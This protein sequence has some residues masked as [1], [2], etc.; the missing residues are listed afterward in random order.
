[1]SDHARA[2][3]RVSTI[4]PVYNGAATIARAIDSALAQDFEGQEIIVVNDG[5]TDDTAEA[6]AQY[7]DQI[8][9]VNKPNGGAASA[10]NTGIAIAKG[11]FVAFLD[12]DDIWLPGHLKALIEPLMRQP[13]A[14]LAFGDFETCD[15]DGNQIYSSVFAA[16]PQRACAPSLEEMLSGFFTILPSAVA[17]RRRSF[18]SAGGFDEGF[19]KAAWEDFH[20]WLLLREHGPFIPVREIITHHIDSLNAI[21]EKYLPGRK[22]FKKLV[23]S[24]FGKRSRNLIKEVDLYFATRFFARAVTHLKSSRYIEGCRDLVLAIRY[25]PV[26]VVRNANP[27]RRGLKF[28]RQLRA[29]F[30]FTSSNQ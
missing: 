13:V 27:L 11:E 21:P 25:G 4:I 28:A 6:L 9:V 2:A 12:A 20:F 8:R 3:I 30:S 17:V 7:G 26:W 10:R 14:A 24:R 22:R 18:D 5:S 16:D 19:K 29:N 23:W 15:E 1:M